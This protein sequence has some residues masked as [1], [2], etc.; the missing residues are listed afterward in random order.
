MY[1]L[2][3]I[4]MQSKFLDQLT[5]NKSII[6]ACNQAIKKA[7][8]DKAYILFVE[9][10]GY[11]RTIPE[12]VSIANKGDYKNIS[13]VKKFG[14]DGGRELIKTIDSFNFPKK[15]KV[16]G[17]NTDCCVLATVQGYLSA[18]NYIP[19]FNQSK[20]E[21]LTRACGSAWNHEYGIERLKQLALDNPK[22]KVM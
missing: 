17:I 3:V 11:D 13:H 20:V 22:L 18:I 1:T 6:A 8:E 19:E 14:D 15:I 7:V 21:V 4:D 16:V 2:A 9:Y 10:Y 5:N 12:L